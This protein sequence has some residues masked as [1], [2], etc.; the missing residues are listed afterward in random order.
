MEPLFDSEPSFTAVA[1]GAFC[2]AGTAELEVNLEALFTQPDL[3]KMSAKS[4]KSKQSAYLH[5]RLSY[6]GTDVPFITTGYAQVASCKGS[7]SLADKDKDLDYLEG[8]DVGGF[9]IQ[10][11]NDMPAALGLDEP[12]SAAVL[13]AFGGKIRCSGKKMPTGLGCFRGDT[14]VA[15]EAGLRPIR[16]IKV[17]ERVWSFDEKSGLRKLAKVT[18][19]YVRPARQLRRLQIGRDTLHLTDSHPIWIEGKGWLRA[20]AVAAGDIAR[21]DDGQQLA[22]IGNEPSDANTFFA[23]YDRGA[24]L[25][26]AAQKPL[27]AVQKAAFSTKDGASAGAVYNIEVEGSH[28]YYVGAQRILVHNK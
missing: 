19:T 12:T 1:A 9:S 7:W 26:A 6:G 14:M 2:T 25:V 13:A 22:V 20:N 10:C 24:D 8:L 21:T 4:A 16:E 27:Y 17:G 11:G 28:N 3:I 23:G 5:V 15:T 18:E